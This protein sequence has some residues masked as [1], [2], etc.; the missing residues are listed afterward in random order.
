VDKIRIAV[1]GA[2]QDKAV[3]EAFARDGS[4][5]ATS[6]PEELRRIIETDHAKYGAL[7][8]TLNIKE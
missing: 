8:K 3:I 2:L 6:T 7:I 1:L 4:E 5:I